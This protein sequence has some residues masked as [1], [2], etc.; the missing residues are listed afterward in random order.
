VRYQSAAR[1]QWQAHNKDK[2]Q[3]VE[4]L[5]VGGPLELVSETVAEGQY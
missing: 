5:G 4:R 2:H 3:C 1:P